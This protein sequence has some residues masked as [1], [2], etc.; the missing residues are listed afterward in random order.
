[1]SMTAIS[2][3]IMPA[4]FA[5]EVFSLKSIMAAIVTM[6]N[7]PA[8]L[9]GNTMAPGSVVSASSSALLLSRLNV[10]TP[11]PYIASVGLI[12]FLFRWAI[13]VTS[14]VAEVNMA[15]KK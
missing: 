3:I 2:V 4:M 9:T 11:M 7:E 1:M 14:S 13:G 10:P 12:W 5:R 8:L 6:S 15:R